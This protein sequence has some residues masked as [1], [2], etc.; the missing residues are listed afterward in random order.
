MEL[1]SLIE[2]AAAGGAS[3]LHLEAGMPAA[4]RVRGELRVS[5]EIIAPKTL[6]AM[7]RALLGE[8]QWPVFLERR[9]FDM[10]RTIR[11]VR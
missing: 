8:E 11:G 2:A 7:A 3:D 10:S 1:E 6:T 4:L 9:S 5:G